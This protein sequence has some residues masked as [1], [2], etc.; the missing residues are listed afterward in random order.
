MDKDLEYLEKAIETTETPEPAAEGDNSG[1]ADTNVGVDN[2]T[3]SNDAG[4]NVE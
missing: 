3:G 2:T 1:G 4:A